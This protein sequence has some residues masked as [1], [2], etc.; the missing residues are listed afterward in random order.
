M[1]IKIAREDLEVWA[2]FILDHSLDGIKPEDVVMI[3]GERITW[4]LMSVLQDKIFAA[5]AIA[6][7]NL[8]APDNNRGQVWG[9]SIARFGSADQIKRVPRW[10]QLRYETMT[11]YIEILGAEIPGLYAN[12]PEATA[13]EM[14]KVD[15]TYKNIRLAKRWVLTLF[16]TQA[17]AEMEGMSLEAYTDIIVK[18]STV[19]PR[20]LE[21]VEEPIYQLMKNS[22]EVL[23]Q[24]EEPRTGR[25]LKLGMDISGRNCVKCTGKRN[26]PDGEVYTSPDANS[27][28]GEIFLDLP[29]Y[30]DGVIIEGI[31][32]K[33]KGGV[34]K[35][36]RAEKE[37]DTLKKIIDTDNGS[38]RVG[39]VALGM[40]S[41]IQRALKHPMFV[42]KVGGTL[43]IA[44]GASY[45]ECFVD[46]PGSAVGQLKTEEFFQK[47]MLNRSAQH[48]DIV[49]DFRP[50]GAGQSVHLDFTRLEI[51]DN[52]W[53]IP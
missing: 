44:L 38:R 19:D 11:K 50:G 23:I 12:L 2:D 21:E 31:Y 13:K 20:L 6:D 4:P 27:V 33:F 42:E 28:A 16:P 26:F 40:N 51:K 52:I 49:T 5:G 43:H 30:Y 46:D 39:E 36:Y 14:M 24:T 34:I 1:G 32:L 7:I 3:K 17:F 47:G 22:D 45:P 10:H 41:G 8:V 18:A 35:D 25:L 53:V 37:H 9:A 48:V 15:E 29:V